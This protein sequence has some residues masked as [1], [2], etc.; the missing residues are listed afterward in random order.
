[1]T[2]NRLRVLVVEDSPT[3]RELL[4]YRFCDLSLGHPVRVDFA[5]DG[6]SATSMILDKSLGYAAVVSDLKIPW[7]IGMGRSDVEVGFSFLENA[8]R[9]EP[10]PRVIVMTSDDDPDVCERLRNLGIEDNDIFEKPF[11]FELLVRA[12]LSAIG[13]Q[14]AAV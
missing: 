7:E 4:Y 5:A 3:T 14:R 9:L 12:V 13:L 2:D 6:N 10:R 8:V 1:M 11:S